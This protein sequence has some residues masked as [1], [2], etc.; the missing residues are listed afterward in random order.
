[1]LG[2]VLMPTN[3]SGTAARDLCSAPLLVVMPPG[4]PLCG[5][6]AVGPKDL[7]GH[8]LISYSRDQPIG[9]EIDERFVLADLERHIAIEITQSATACSLVAAGAGVAVVDGY[10]LMN[11]TYSELEVRPF[12]PKIEITS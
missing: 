12:R 9:L 7:R 5:L 1:D 10:A 2:L 8:A 3:H 6:D 11:K 4:H